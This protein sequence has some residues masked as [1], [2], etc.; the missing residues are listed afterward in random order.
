M[1]VPCEHDPPL[2]PALDP[3]H[4]G[5]MYCPDCRTYVSGRTTLY[6]DDQRVEQKRRQKEYRK[7]QGK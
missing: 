3:A 5:Q 1:K 4:R 2:I 7:G 6:E